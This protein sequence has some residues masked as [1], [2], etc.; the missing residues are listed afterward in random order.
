MQPHGAETREEQRDAV[1]REANRRDRHDSDLEELH[2]AN[3]TR[4]LDL[5]GHL[6][7]GRREQKE[8]Q[9]EDPRRQVH[10]RVGLRL[11]GGREREQ[12]HDRVLEDVVVERSEEL[13]PEKGAEA[14]LAEEAELAHESWLAG[15]PGQTRGFPTLRG[16]ALRPSGTSDRLELMCGRLALT[17]PRSVAEQL[18]GCAT[19]PDVWA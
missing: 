7:R 11:G 5:V 17:D 9:D 2:A 4:L 1:P 12:N 19:M 14:F 3:E 15:I 6:A 8:R 10:E 18:L 16:E 13:G